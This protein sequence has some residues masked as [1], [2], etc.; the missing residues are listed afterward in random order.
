MFGD[1]RGRQTS[2]VLFYQTEIELILDGPANATTGTYQYVA[3]NNAPLL[4]LNERR[5]EWSDR[6]ELH[7]F[8]VDGRPMRVV[9]LSRLAGARTPD[10]ILTPDDVMVP[11]PNPA[12]PDLSAN[13][14]L[15][16]LYPVPRGRHGYG[17]P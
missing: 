13:A 11:L 8:V 14:L 10:F 1:W 6:W 15:S 3:T 12:H 16:S 17:R 9:H 7:P 4:G 5:F 2:Q